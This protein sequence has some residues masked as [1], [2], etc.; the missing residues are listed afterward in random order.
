MYNREYTPERITELNP[1]D[2]IVFG[3]RSSSAGLLPTGCKNLEGSFNDGPARLAFE[4]F[5]ANRGQGVGLQEQSYAI[6][7]IQGDAASNKAYVDEFIKF[8]LNHP[9][10]NFIVTRLE[11]GVAG[12]SLGDIASLFTKVIDLPN[13]ILPKEYVQVLLRHPDVATWAYHV[14]DAKRDFLDEYHSLTERMM[15]GEYDAYD[16]LKRYAETSLIIL[17]LW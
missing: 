3:S 2:I 16:K 14:W 7:I 1:N 15:R 5:A 12:V 9:E 10:Y 4:R 8:A 17:L 13:V 11:C 6:P